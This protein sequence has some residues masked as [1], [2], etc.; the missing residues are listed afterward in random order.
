MHDTY[1]KAHPFA[2][3]PPRWR[4]ALLPRSTAP[5][6]SQA[7]RQPQEKSLGN[8]SHEQGSRSFGE[9]EPGADD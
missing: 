1:T 5:A 2:H 9:R 7:F 4:I 6:K 8:V 3:G